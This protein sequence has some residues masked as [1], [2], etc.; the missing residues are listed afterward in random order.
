MAGNEKKS[1]NK[2]RW[3]T[4]IRQTYQI[5]RRSD[6]KI[7][8][9]L[10][11]IFLGILVVFVV[12]ALLLPVG[13]ITK[14]L[15]IVLGV[16]VALLATSFVFGRRAERAAYSEIAGQTGAAAA[17]L[18]SMRGT[19]FTTPAVAVTKNE[20]LIHMVIGRPGVILVGEG[21]PSRIKHLMANQR[22]KTERW[23]PDTPITEIYVGDGD[24]EVPLPK[25]QR[26]L[27]KMPKV[28]RPAEVT[29]VRRKLDAAQR[30]SNPVPIPKGP[31]PKSGRAARTPKNQR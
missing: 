3:W 31:L 19:W 28:L 25:L 18:D 10:A 2:T 8:W 21:A 14:V 5:A 26:T 30:M 13:T 11:A 4:T 12:G 20:D 27:G 9:I 7:G 15:V 29:E 17:V 22:K 16:S 6:P 1:G 23:V 24:G